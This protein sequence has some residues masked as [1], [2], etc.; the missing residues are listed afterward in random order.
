MSLEA[1]PVCGHALSTI[2]LHCPRCPAPLALPHFKQ[3]HAKVSAEIVLGVVILSLL[4]YLLFF[5]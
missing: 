2:G 1:C 5:S 4:I 3:S